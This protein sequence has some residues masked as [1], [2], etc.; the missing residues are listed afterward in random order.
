[1]G[2]RVGRIGDDAKQIVH[3][4]GPLSASA[5]AGLSFYDLAKITT[6]IHFFR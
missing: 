2:T 1:M 6:E 4:S 5:S 3:P